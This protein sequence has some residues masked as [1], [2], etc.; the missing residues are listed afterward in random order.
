MRFK[1]YLQ[2][3]TDMKW[4]GDNVVGKKYKGMEIINAVFDDKED[5]MVKFWVKDSKTKKPKEI[6]PISRDELV[7]VLK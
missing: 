5:K 1:D 3:K 7:K 2:E 4:L 6:R